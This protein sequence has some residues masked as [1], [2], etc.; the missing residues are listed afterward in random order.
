MFDKEKNNI[1]PYRY[2]STYYTTNQQLFP[3]KVKKKFL[4]YKLIAKF[5]NIL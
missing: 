2:F 4:I 5:A 1:S 3:K